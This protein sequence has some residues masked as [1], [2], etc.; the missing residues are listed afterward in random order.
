MVRIYCFLFLLLLYGP[1]GAQVLK[2]TDTARMYNAVEIFLVPKGGM[3]N[4]K[5]HWLNY[6]KEV[7]REGRLDKTIYADHIFEI[8][9]AKEGIL[10][11]GKSDS[12]DP[13]LID[14][15]RKQK[16]WSPGIQ[17]GRPICYLLKLKVPKELFDQVKMEELIV[18]GDLFKQELLGP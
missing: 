14:F 7:M 12:K 15:L 16:R 13:V 18:R 17:S 10:L 4:F 3:N 9:V 6:L 5:T 8:I 11:G 2:N 1:V